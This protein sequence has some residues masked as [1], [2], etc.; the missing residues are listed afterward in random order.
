MN[1]NVYIYYAKIIGMF[2]PRNLH[3]QVIDYSELKYLPKRKKYLS[4]KIRFHPKYNKSHQIHVVPV[5]LFGPIL[6]I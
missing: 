4:L 3:G 1:I 6:K 5:Y 2:D